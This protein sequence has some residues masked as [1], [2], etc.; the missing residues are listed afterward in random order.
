MS[1]DSTS[2]FADIGEQDWSA[3]LRNPESASA[4]QTSSTTTSP[5][6]RSQDGSPS[7]SCSGAGSGPSHICQRPSPRASAS[8]ANLL[9]LTELRKAAWAR[10][11]SSGIATGHAAIST[12]RAPTWK[13]FDALMI[14]RHRYIAVDPRD[15]RTLGWAACFHPCPPWSQL[16]DD[17]QDGGLSDS[18]DGR[19]GRIAEVQV[20]VAEAERNRGVGSFLVKAIVASLDADSRYSTVQA[21]FFADHH[22]ARKLFERCRFEAV[23]TRSKAAKMLDGPQR[24]VWRDLVTVEYRLP[25]LR[26]QPSQQLQ[27]ISTDTCFN[28]TV[29]DPN[30]VLKRPRLE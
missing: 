23:G 26:Q 1:T 9:A 22:G 13:Q 30:S 4:P 14:K 3:F 6:D 19:R 18:D 24:G 16:Y 8:V 25:P 7:A 29:V 28:E 15:N 21:C 12:S 10:I 27:S 20:M 11:Y 17:D 5:C 2:Q